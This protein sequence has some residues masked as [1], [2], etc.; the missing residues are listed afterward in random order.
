MRKG[1]DGHV[2][3]RVT[4]AEQRLG[5]ARVDLAALPD[6][7]DELARCVTERLPVEGLRGKPASKAPLRLDVVHLTDVRRK[8]GWDGDDPR[9]VDVAD[10]YGVAAVLESWTRVLAEELPD[11]PD[12]AEVATVRSE[13]ALLIEHWTWIDDQQ[14]AEELAEDVATLARQVRAALGIRPAERYRCPQCGD[15]AYTMPGGFLSCPSGHERSVRDLELQQRRRPPLPTAEVCAEYG[16]E[17]SRLWQWHKR[18]KI[19]PVESRG[20]SLM[21]L[22]WDV[23]C[24]VNPDIAAALDARDVLEAG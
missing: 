14:W 20:R 11:Y 8:P 21:W 4:T 18:H 22:P 13:A 3:G 10:R 7:V 9:E 15:R 12:M 6:L 5:Q 2:G 17:V 16:I 24:L 23:F 1:A 19:K